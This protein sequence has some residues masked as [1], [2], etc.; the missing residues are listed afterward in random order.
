MRQ[1]HLPFDRVA[2]LAAQHVGHP[3]HRPDLAEQ[4]LNSGFATAGTDHVQYGQRADKHPF[5]PVLADDPSGEPAPA[6]AGV[7]SEHTIGLASTGARI[8][9]TATSSGPRARPSMLLI[10]PSLMDNEKISSSK[11]ASRSMPMA[12]A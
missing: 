7:S 2:T 10:A 3:D 1:T 11:P 6:K 8:V 9:A 12:W 5:P 4:F